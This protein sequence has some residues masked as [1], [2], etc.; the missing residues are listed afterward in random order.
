MS[1]SIF[2]INRVVGLAL[3][4]SLAAALP[5]L[6][7]YP[8]RPIKM[9]VPYAAGGSSDIIGR[10]VGEFLER[11]IGQPIII[12]NIGGAGGAAGTQRAVAAAPDGYTLLLGANSELLIN[13]ALQPSLPY[14]ASRDLTPIGLVAAGAIVFL[15]KAGLPAKTW[16]E[17]MALAGSSPNGI[18][19]GTSGH[20]TI[21]HLGGEMAKAKTK[22]KMTHVPYRGAGPLMND[23]VGGHVDTGIATLASARAFIES[24]KV[25]ALAVLSEQRTE[26]AKDI[27][28][29][30]EL[31]NLSEVILETWYGVFTPAN[32]PGPIATKLEQAVLGVL[33]DPK[34][35]DKLAAQAISIR[36]MPADQFR[37]FVAREGEKYRGIVSEAKITLQ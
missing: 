27:P 26:F 1:Y 36:R 3:A 11:A 10:V 5:A 17:L 13:K 22:I 20:G 9:I 8:E 32:L 12:E 16:P 18:N 34:F 2:N 23:L 24:G 7:E 30:K 25:R 29:V 35:K 28:S 4:A 37:E 21:Q 19:Y 15:G 31:P 33:D 14:D 6:A